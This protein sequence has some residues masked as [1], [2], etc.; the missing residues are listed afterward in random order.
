[1]VLTLLAA[2]AFA[3]KGLAD[4]DPLSAVAANAGLG[5]AGSVVLAY[6]AAYVA[7]WLFA[8]A[9]MAAFEV[10]HTDALGEWF[11]RRVL[12]LEQGTE[13]PAM[14]M[15]WFGIGGFGGLLLLGLLG[16]ALIAALWA[17]PPVV[18]LTAVRGWSF[19]DA[20]SYVAFVVSEPERQVPPVPFGLER[21]SGDRLGLFLF[22]LIAWSGVAAVVLAVFI[23]WV[24][25]RTALKRRANNVRR[26]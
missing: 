22:D 15:F 3:A 26:G 11:Y 2:C 14:A 6:L 20:M 9:A 7:F 5:G 17:I 4:G 18:F 23:G 8:G 19:G 24:A 10:L 25:L 16:G 21:V 1:M 12:G 13:P